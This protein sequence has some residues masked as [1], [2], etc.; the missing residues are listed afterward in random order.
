M[1][2]VFAAGASGIADEAGWDIVRAG[3]RFHETGLVA[4]G[5]AVL[6]GWWLVLST[7]SISAAPLTVYAAASLHESLKEVAAAYEKQ[8]GDRVTFSFGTG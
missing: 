7:G 6:I 2:E 3:M 8:T 1:P 5:C 4:R